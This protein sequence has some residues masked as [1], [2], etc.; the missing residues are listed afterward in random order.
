MACIFQRLCGCIEAILGLLQCRGPGCPQS[1]AGECSLFRRTAGSLRRPLPNRPNESWNLC[2]IQEKSCLATGGH[3][4]RLPEAVAVRVV[5]CC[6]PGHRPSLGRR[7][8]VGEV[9]ARRGPG[10]PAPVRRA[11]RPKRPAAARAVRFQIQWVL[12][13]A[14]KRPALLEELSQGGSGPWGTV[15][16]SSCAL[17]PER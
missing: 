16:S 4:R 8:P 3:D 7:R 14:D 2:R 11:S 13:W 1:P 9:L 12:G 6:T 15:P 17:G 5:S 10:I